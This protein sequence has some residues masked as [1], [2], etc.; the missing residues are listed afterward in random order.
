MTVARIACDVDPLYSVMKKRQLVSVG[1]GGRVG[2]ERTGDAVC[3][4]GL[5]SSPPG[6]A[7][8]VEVGSC[9]TARGVN[10]CEKADRAS[11]EL[12]PSRATTSISRTEYMD[13]LRDAREVV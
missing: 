3:F 5:G 1:A 6:A 10:F 4:V 12:L 8:S 11:V 7:L 13:E 9:L 2:P